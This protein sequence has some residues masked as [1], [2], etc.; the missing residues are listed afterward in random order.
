M[1]ARPDPMGGTRG[2]AIAWTVCLSLGLSAPLL[3]V[4]LGAFFDLSF[5]GVS[6]ESWTGGGPRFA[7][8]AKDIL[9]VYGRALT[10]SAGLA[11]ATVVGAL[12]LGVP[13]ALSLVASPP[14]L[15]VFL[16][17]LILAPVSLPGI[18]VAVALIQTYGTW[19]GGPGLLAAAHLLYALPLVVRLLLDA[20]RTARLEQLTACARTLGANGLQRFWLVTYPTL[21]RPLVSGASL[22]FAVSW[23]EFNVSYLL[24]TPTVQTFPAALYATYPGNS[25]Q[26]ASTATVL[27]LAGLLPALG[28][29]Q[30]LGGGRALRQAA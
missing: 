25:S 5:L 12:T 8:S 2:A 19:R 21:R 4:C 23:G 1:K 24:N 28:A 16:E 13:T 26:Y 22:A 10:V 6:T 30:A 29:L 11:T 18:A 20:L 27:F 17:G 3:F 7:S 15:R 14:S 9:S